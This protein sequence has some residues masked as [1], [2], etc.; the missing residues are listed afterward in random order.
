MRLK[1]ALVA[2]RALALAPYMTL[3]ISGDSV[4]ERRIV[5][6]VREMIRLLST[7]DMA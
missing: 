5:N 4:V 2:S 7:S 6:L 3:K 1:T